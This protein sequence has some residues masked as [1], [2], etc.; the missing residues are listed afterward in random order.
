MRDCDQN[1]KMICFVFLF[2]LSK[3]DNLYRNLI[4][5]GFLSNLQVENISLVI[6]GERESSLCYY[7]YAYSV[8]LYLHQV[9]PNRS[10]F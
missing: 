1:K 5:N 10:A 7:Y 4:L 6:A 9:V 8:C 3:E 2:H